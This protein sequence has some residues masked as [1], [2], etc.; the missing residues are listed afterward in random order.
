MIPSP[1]LHTHSTASDGTLTP[2]Q[3]V[4]RAAVAGVRVLALTDHD[5]VAGI[6]EAQ[7]TATTVGVKL[8]AGVE[9]SVTW[10]GR[11]IHIVGLG[12]DSNNSTLEHGLITQRQFRTWRAEE[13]AQRLA[14]VGYPDALAGAQAYANGVVIGR[15]HFARFLVARGAAPDVRSIFKRFLVA[16]KPGYVP[17][18]WT[19]LMTAVNWIKTAGGQAVI[20][21]PARYQLTASKR[22]Q[23]F[24]E[25]SRAGGRAIEVISGSHSR[26]D[27]FNYANYAAEHQFLASA[28]SDYHGPEQP[29]IELGQLPALPACCTPIWHDWQ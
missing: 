19:D 16:G 22:R 12:I 15:T 26:D 9:I 23:L 3:L 27:V 8:I 2:T 24:N 28:G 11:T 29:W 1:D 21:H 14:K 20:A 7:L 6:D 13:M 4:T 25:F 5:T 10:L 18:E 17:S